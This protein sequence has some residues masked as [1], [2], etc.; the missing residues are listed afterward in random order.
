MMNEPIEL[1]DPR[2]LAEEI[3]RRRAELDQCRPCSKSPTLP[4]NISESI[5]ADAARVA[6]TKGLPP[7]SDVPVIQIHGVYTLR[8]AAEL[9][10]LKSSCLPRECRLGRLKYSKRGGRV[11]FLGS[12]LIEWVERG[13]V[14]RQRHAHT[15]N[16]KA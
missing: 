1:P 12:W 2:Q 13:E 4:R 15:R 7:M 10:S 6:A 8:T 11:L 9:L 5:R 14:T 16:G 3:R